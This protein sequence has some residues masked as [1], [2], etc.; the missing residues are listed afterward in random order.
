M[1]LWI[2]TEERPKKSVISQIISKVC[3]DKKIKF[4]EKD[5]LFKPLFNGKFK[6]FHKNRGVNSD[7][8]AK[9]MDRFKN[10]NETIGKDNNL[11]E[12]FKIGH[13]FFTNF[14]GIQE[15]EAWYQHIIN[16]EIAPLLREYWF[17]SLDIAEKEIGK[18]K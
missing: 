15:P 18:L 14:G 17:D 1:D 6:A 2:L 11:G 13:S 9:V 4:V 5:I 10:L 3:N 7:I 8:T 16:S 12:G